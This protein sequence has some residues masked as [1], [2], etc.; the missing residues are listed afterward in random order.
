MMGE[1]RGW[2]PNTLQV[3]TQTHTHCGAACIHPLLPAVRPLATLPA[4][5][6]DP[7]TLQGQKRGA[8]GGWSP[9][10][11][12]RRA[13]VAPP[14]SLAFFPAPPTLGR[15]YGGPARGRRAHSCR[16]SPP[17][18]LILSA[19]SRYRNLCSPCGVWRG[20]REPSLPF[21]P[22]GELW[23]LREELRPEWGGRPL[24]P[25][26]CEGKWGFRGAKTGSQ[27]ALGS[28]R[29]GRRDCRSWTL[30]EVLRGGALALRRRRPA[31]AGSGSWPQGLPRMLGRHTARI[32]PGGLSGWLYPAL[33]G[34]CAGR[35][36]CG[37]LLRPKWRREPVWGLWEAAGAGTGAVWAMVLPRGLLC[38]SCRVWSLPT[39]TS[40]MS[41]FCLRS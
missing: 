37:K 29:T 36:L 25:C 4:P 18:L 34:A 3:H 10:G 40:L 32:V 31:R 8:A 11:G 39:G 38:P 9:H 23:E 20:E 35:G 41:V 30:R 12:Q 14:L 22:H 26:A 17:P 24:E 6:H 15:N 5:A 2:T 21:C 28:L 27:P 19:S 13:G 33:D 7:T 1:G 16:I